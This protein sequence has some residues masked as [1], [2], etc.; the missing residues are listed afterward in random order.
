M[1]AAALNAPDKP[2]TFIYA[3]CDPDTGDVCYVGKMVLSLFIGGSAEESPA[4]V[5]LCRAYDRL[6]ALSDAVKP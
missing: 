6:R 3:L 1:Q 2:K 5:D 4:H